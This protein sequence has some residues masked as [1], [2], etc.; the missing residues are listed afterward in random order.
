VRLDYS[1]TGSAV[2][3]STATAAGAADATLTA[4]TARTAEPAVTTRQ[5]I[6]RRTVAGVEFHPFDGGYLSATNIALAP[7]EV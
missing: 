7:G 4:A 6:A 3:A 2:A 1:D 5:H